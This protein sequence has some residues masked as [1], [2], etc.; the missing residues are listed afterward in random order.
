MRQRL[1]SKSGI[2][3][4]RGLEGP[5]AKRHGGHQLAMVR[6]LPL[7]HPRVGELVTA[8][9][10]LLSRGER[11]VPLLLPEMRGGNADHH[12][13]QPDVGEIGAVSPAAG[14]DVCKAAFCDRATEL[15]QA[16]HR[17]G[18]RCWDRKQRGHRPHPG[19]QQKRRGQRGGS[20][21]PS[22]GPQRSLAGSSPRQEGTG[23]HD[24]QDEDEQRPCCAVVVA[25]AH[26]PLLAQQSR[27]QRQDGPPQHNRHD[28]DQEH[29]LE[30]ESAF[31]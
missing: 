28:P 23:A 11:D 24:D 16:C 2:G 30:H 20:E 21:G 26:H 29:V 27:D 22:Q 25:L 10:D 12:H 7:L 5:V 18:E 8:D 15:D 4:S 31:A 1:A 19:D 13:D 3:G 9:R 17:R 6:K 14:E